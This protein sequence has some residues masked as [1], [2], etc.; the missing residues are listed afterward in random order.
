M[1]SAAYTLAFGSLTQ[2]VAPA[3]EPVTR[4]EAKLFCRVDGDSD[5]SLFDDVVIPAARE[6]VELFT[7]RALINQTLLYSLPEFPACDDGVIRLPK[8]PLASVTSIAYVD[9]DGASQT[10][11]SWQS[12][13]R[14]SP[15][16]IKPAYDASWPATRDVLNAV[17]ITYVAG[18]G[19]SGS[20]VPADIRK[21]LLTLILHFYDERAAIIAGAAAE[22]PK[23]VDSLLW[24]YRVLLDF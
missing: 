3:S 15:G 16:R 6:H 4:A 18:Y 9:T 14:S 1:S 22:T 24:P 12:D 17:T 5:D 13:I 21:A 8:P 2:S 20:S 11:D 23:A 10:V 19:A 7:G